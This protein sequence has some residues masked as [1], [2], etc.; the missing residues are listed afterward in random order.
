[1]TQTPDAEGPMHI[2]P[3]GHGDVPG[4][5]EPDE[6]AWS[7]ARTSSISGTTLVALSLLLSVAAFVL[8][9]VALVD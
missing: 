6:L 2:G 9:I 5:H 7:Y 3:I 4:E 1:V 8:A